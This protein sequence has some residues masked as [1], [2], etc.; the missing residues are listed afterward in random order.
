MENIDHKKQI[1]NEIMER[2]NQEASGCCTSLSCG[3]PLYFLDPKPEENLLDIGYGLGMEMMKASAMVG[4]EG[5]V[6]GIDVSPAMQKAAAQTAQEQGINNCEFLSGEAENIPIKDQMVDGV[7]SNCVINHS[8]DKLKVYKEIYRVLKPGGRFVISDIYAKKELPEEIRN[9]PN[10]WAQ[11]IG[12][13]ITKEEYL[14]AIQ[15]AGFK[16]VSIIQE[17]LSPK[18][19][20]YGIYNFTIKAVKEC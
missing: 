10:M 5:K 7:F 1:K 9:D 8:L 4:E 16:S 6:Y 3:Q 14:D 19:A 12:G 13:A 2:Y 15:S 11:C 20:Q 17:N 18:K